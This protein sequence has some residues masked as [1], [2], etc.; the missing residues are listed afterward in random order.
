MLMHFIYFVFSL[1]ELVTSSAEFLNHNLLL[2]TLLNDSNFLFKKWK[3][4]LLSLLAESDLNSETI[5]QKYLQLFYIRTF[6]FWWCR[7]LFVI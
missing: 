4:L 6:I 5:D 3:I 1:T 2:F 7:E